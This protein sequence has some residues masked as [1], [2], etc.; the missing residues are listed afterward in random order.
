MPNYQ[1]TELANYMY[2]MVGNILRMKLSNVQ[3]KSLVISTMHNNVHT[4]KDEAG[5]HRVLRQHKRKCGYY[6]PNG[7]LLLYSNENAKVDAKLVIVFCTLHENQ[8][9]DTLERAEPNQKDELL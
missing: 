1:R 9:Y 3:K 8:Y 5:R 7:G 4:T 2:T 6:G